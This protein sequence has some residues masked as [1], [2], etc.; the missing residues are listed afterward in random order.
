MCWSTQAC[1]PTRFPT[2]P[3]LPLSLISSF[4][5]LKPTRV[6]A[7]SHHDIANPPLFRQ[8]P[9]P[10]FAPEHLLRD[11]PFPPLLRPHQCSSP[12]T[13]SRLNDSGVVMSDCCASRMPEP[14]SAR[15]CSQR[16]ADTGQGGEEGK[17]G[18][19]HGVERL[20]AREM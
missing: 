5:S 10:F 1:I 16:A 3:S 17:G 11:G 18:G 13:A 4:T 20:G 2:A 8:R 6:P 9:L 19:V 7:L 12:S 14:N 15:I